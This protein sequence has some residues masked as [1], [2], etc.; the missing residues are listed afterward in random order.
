MK[1]DI[2]ELK[3]DDLEEVSGG[4]L[5][6]MQTTICPTCGTEMLMGMK[7]PKCNPIGQ[8]GKK[9]ICKNCGKEITSFSDIGKCIFCKTAIILTPSENEDIKYV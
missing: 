7:C 8:T 5:P 3:M 6:V 9:L 4:T 2:N 1:D